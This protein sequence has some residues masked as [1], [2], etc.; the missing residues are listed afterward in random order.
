MG[1]RK[2]FMNFYL[3][4]FCLY[5]V[6]VGIVLRIVMIDELSFRNRL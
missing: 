4:V 3:V 5:G 2:N 1:I 6:D